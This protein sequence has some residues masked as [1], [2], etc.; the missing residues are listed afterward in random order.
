MS[1]ALK[2]GI[3]ATDVADLAAFCTWITNQTLHRRDHITEHELEDARDEAVVLA[4]ELYSTWDPER[5]GFA[6]Y[7]RAA[8]PHKLISWWRVELRQSGL[9][10]CSNGTYRYHGRVSLDVER[11]SDDDDSALIHN[12]RRGMGG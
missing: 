11:E 9:G 1:A 4:C 6:T 7:L 2:P 3:D 10:S 5:G 12:D 8:L